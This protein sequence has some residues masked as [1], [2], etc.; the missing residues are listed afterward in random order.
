[1]QIWDS[2]GKYLG[3]P[4]IWGPPKRQAIGWI[5]ERIISKI[6]GW[7][8]I[9]LKVRLGKKFLSNRS[10]KHFPLMLC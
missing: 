10:F 6:G 9:F 5:K 2:L 7:N 8:K 3:I 1:M 4:T